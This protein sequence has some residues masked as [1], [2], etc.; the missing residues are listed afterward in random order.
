MT[1]AGTVKFNFETTFL[2]VFNSFC[3]KIKGPLSVQQI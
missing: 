1:L 3:I 2:V